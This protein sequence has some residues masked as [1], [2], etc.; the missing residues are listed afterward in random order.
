MMFIKKYV[1]R[2]FNYFRRR[3]FN[4]Y[5]LY[6]HQCHKIVEKFNNHLVFNFLDIYLYLKKIHRKI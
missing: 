3:D 5:L 4:N 6:L 1:E 2:F